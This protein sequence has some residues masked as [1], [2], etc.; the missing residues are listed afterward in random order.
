M[1]PAEGVVQPYLLI[2]NQ[3]IAQVSVRVGITIVAAGTTV[4]GKFDRHKET[5]LTERMFE[6]LAVKGCRQWVLATKQSSVG[7]LFRM[8]AGHRD[9]R[10]ALKQSTKGIPTHLQ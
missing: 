9:A 7:R 3:V 8:R 1:A 2:P 4:F 10:S 5:A 6:G